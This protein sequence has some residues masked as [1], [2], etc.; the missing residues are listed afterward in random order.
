MPKEYIRKTKQYEVHLTCRAFAK[1]IITANNS[2]EAECKALELLAT[3]P[4]TLTP[5]D[6]VYDKWKVDVVVKQ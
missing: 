3:A 4:Q 1:T 5:M 2:V 6:G